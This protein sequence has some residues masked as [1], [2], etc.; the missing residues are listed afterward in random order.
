M[1]ERC[2]LLELYKMKTD[3]LPSIRQYDSTY[4][5]I[6]RILRTRNQI[7]MPDIHES[8][9]AAS[10]TGHVSNIV[11]SSFLNRTFQP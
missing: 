9:K 11:D 3:L 1:N 4:F 10:R 8:N 6:L 2:L 5:A 7:I